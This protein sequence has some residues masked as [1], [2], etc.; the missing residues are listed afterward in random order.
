VAADASFG[1][2][3]AYGYDVA[4]NLVDMNGVARVYNTADQ[5]IFDGT[6]ALAYDAAGNLLGDGVNA[7]TWDTAGRLVGIGAGDDPAYTFSYNGDGDRV[8]QTAGD[9]TTT[10]TLDSTPAL[11][12]VVGEA[13]G[14]QRTAFIHDAR[15]IHAQVGEAPAY[16]VTDGLGSVRAWTGAAMPDA[17]ITYDPY[18]TPDTDI[19]GFAFTGEPRDATGLQ[20]H[21]ARY[22]DPALGAWASLDQ[23]ETPNRY[24]YV[25]GN[26]VNWTDPSGLQPGALTMACVQAA[27]PFPGFYDD[28]VC[29][30]VS[31]VESIP[32]TLERVGHAFQSLRQDLTPTVQ[33]LAGHS[34][35]WVGDS[36]MDLEFH[37]RI[38]DALVTG[39]YTMVFPSDGVL[40]PPIPDA[41]DQVWGDILWQLWQEDACSLPDTMTLAQTYVWTMSSARA[42][43]RD[44]SDEDQQECDPLAFT[45]WWFTLAPRLNSLQA[46]EDWYEYEQ[47]VARVGGLYGNHTRTVVEGPIDADGIEPSRC[48]LVD[49]KFSRDAYSPQNRPAGPNWLVVQLESELARYRLAVLNNSMCRGLTVRTNSLVSYLYFENKLIQAGFVLGVDSLVEYA[50]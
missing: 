40:A 20:Y 42:E 16:A 39:D 3:Y 46:D 24:A 22:Y 17:F 35:V 50:P 7:Y 21:R 15:G 12:L 34:I 47:R 45:A 23:L 38:G 14:P 18:G 31:A 32:R 2:D 9:I 11:T 28:I 36:T 33:Q 8:A 37:R 26:V 29:V 1:A 27:G 10:Y 5:L 19:T 25:D 48:H 41:V 43:D 13:T 6:N 49:A 44:S 30:A 4:G